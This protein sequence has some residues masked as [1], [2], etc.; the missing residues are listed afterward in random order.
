MIYKW[1]T[2]E[3]RARRLMRISPKKKLEWLLEMKEFLSKC[4]SP[5]RAFSQKRRCSKH[6]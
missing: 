3:A 6:P 1:E 5:K 4:S 2:E